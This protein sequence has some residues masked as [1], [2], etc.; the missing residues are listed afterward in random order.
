[1]AMRELDEVLIPR[2]LAEAERVEPQGTVVWFLSGATFATVECR[3]VDNN[4]DGLKTK[5][6]DVA[7][8]TL[9]PS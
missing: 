2:E 1:M 3:V 6:L 7:V 4:P 5:L 9:Q 8:D